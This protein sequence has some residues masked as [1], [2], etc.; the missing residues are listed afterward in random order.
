[1]LIGG[2]DASLSRENQ[3]S[4]GRIEEKKAQDGKVER[5]EKLGVM[6]CFI[7]W[8]ARESVSSGLGKVCQ[9]CI[10]GHPE[11]KAKKW[12]EEIT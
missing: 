9:S 8:P 11:R 10:D 4:V 2:K 6:N 3:N 12:Q 1:M 7:H 5:L